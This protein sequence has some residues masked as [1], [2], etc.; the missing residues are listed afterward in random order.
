MLAGPE[1]RWSTVRTFLP[2]GG[3]PLRGA[4]GGAGGAAA[5]PA[6]LPECRSFAD[7]GPG[8]SVGGCCLGGVPVTGRCEC[9]GG[10]DGDA[11]RAPEGCGA[12]G[13]APQPARLPECRS[14]ADTGP[15]GS[16]GGCR[17]GAWVA[18]DIDL[19]GVEDIGGG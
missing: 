17:L 4:D 12:G 3:A 6:R 7:T 16:V 2:E 19:H 5:P 8:G 9:L 15:G 13:L 18:A 14:F 1:K 10:T 11:W